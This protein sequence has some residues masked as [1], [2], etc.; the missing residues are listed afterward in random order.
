MTRILKF[1]LLTFLLIT[2]LSFQSRQNYNPIYLHITG[3]IYDYKTNKPIK[4]YPIFLSRNKIRY[5][6]FHD[7]DIDIEGKTVTR[8]NG[9]FFIDAWLNKND[10]TFWL[11]TKDFAQI[12]FVGIDTAKLK[13]G[14]TLNVGQIWLV[15]YD[16]ELKE[17]SYNLPKEDSKK[18]KNTREK[19]SLSDLKTLFPN[20]SL[21]KRMT[22]NSIDTTNGLITRLNFGPNMPRGTII[23]SYKTLTFKINV[24]N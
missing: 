2:N 7:D 11:L 8:K 17:E 24:Q 4:K 20:D 16:N 9:Q 1:L 14:D 18:E 13:Y 12:K 21:V 3:T 10:P 5:L 6:T 22:I 15:S 19:Y 23:Q